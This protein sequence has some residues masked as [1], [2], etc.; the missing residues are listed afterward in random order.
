MNIVLTGSQG[1]FGSEFRK[2]AGHNVIGI[3]RDA[4]E[5]LNRMPSLPEAV[6]IHAASD[7]RSPASVSPARLMES[8]VM[9][10][11]RLLEEARRLRVKRFVFLSSCAVY[12]EDMH[13]AEDSS[14]S[15]ISINGVGKLLNEKLI[16]EFC[17]AHG[18]EYQILRIFNMYGG[19]DGFSI[20][21]R[22][23]QA[24]R[25]NMSFVLNNHG[26]AQRDFIHVADVVTIVLGLLG[27]PVRHAYLNIGTGVATRI[28]SLVEWAR[29]AHPELKVEYAKTVTQEAEY[30]RADTGRLTETMKL[31]FIS[32]SDYVLN[33][34]KPV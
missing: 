30:S 5:S 12:G 6:V 19:R 8:N 21:S 33:D 14:L 7:L 1:N 16:S 27:M 4:W 26:V 28:S 9:A 18:I 29:R 24:V 17:S 10:T 23:E 20:V 11:A 13:T 2:R 32:I 22:L 34:F 15:P 3:D 31:D 25:G